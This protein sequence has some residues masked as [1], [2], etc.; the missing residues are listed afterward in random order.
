MTEFTVHFQKGWRIG[1][2]SLRM[3]PVLASTA[4]E[5]VRIA[6]IQF[7]EPGYKITRVD[8][9]ENGSLVIDR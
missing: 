1:A 6:R 7:A 9:F 2:R 5:A 4:I 8:H 3:V